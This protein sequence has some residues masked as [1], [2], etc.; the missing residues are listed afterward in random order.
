MGPAQVQAHKASHTSNASALHTEVGQ[1]GA[2][3]LEQSQCTA[4]PTLL[5]AG[6]VAAF[7]RY[8]AQLPVAAYQTKWVALCHGQK[9]F[10]LV[11]Q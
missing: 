9:A 7:V 2:A 11:L 10:L 3:Q 8:R 5:L 4:V 6:L 1:R